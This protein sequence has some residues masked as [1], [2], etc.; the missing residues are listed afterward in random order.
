MF[1]LS[2]LLWMVLAATVVLPSVTARAGIA[3]TTLSGG[4]L[5][6]LRGGSGWL[7]CFGCCGGND[8]SSARTPYEGKQKAMDCGMPM[9]KK[10]KVMDWELPK[11]S[12]TLPANEVKLPHVRF[13]LGTKKEVQT[14]SALKGFNR[15]FKTMLRVAIEYAPLFLAAAAISKTFNCHGSA[16][17]T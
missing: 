7:N 13:L 6:H 9:M 8:D 1:A 17:G 2:P 14:V 5:K 4:H 16:S 10:Q 15:N 3:T 11:K 12:D